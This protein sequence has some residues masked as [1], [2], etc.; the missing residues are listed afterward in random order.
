[1]TRGDEVMTPQGPGMFWE[2]DGDFAVVEH[3][4]TY[5]ARYPRHEVRPREE[6]DWPYDEL[7]Q[8]EWR[9]EAERDRRAE[10]ELR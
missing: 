8:D 1:M 5:L 9:F 2:Y 7:T 6:D 4:W 3:E 10:R